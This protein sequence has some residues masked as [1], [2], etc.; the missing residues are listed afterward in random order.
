MSLISVNTN[1]AGL[2]L[3]K[4]VSFTLTET[5]FPVKPH[6]KDSFCKTMAATDGTNTKNRSGSSLTLPINEDVLS[7]VDWLA[8][9]LYKLG[10]PDRSLEQW[11]ERLKC[12]LEQA[13][14]EVIIV[15]NV[16]QSFTTQE[17]IKAFFNTLKFRLDYSIGGGE[18]SFIVLWSASGLTEEQK[19]NLYY[20]EL[21]FLDDLE[22]KMWKRTFQ[23][24]E[25]KGI[26]VGIFH[27]EPHQNLRDYLKSVYQ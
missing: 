4:S 8:R 6:A 16:S 1:T 10:R 23:M 5:G 2:P 24:L 22:L 27:F 14:K 21:V 25:E 3:P 20:Q 26:K 7:S 17:I 18:G 9:T 19:N 13:L 11:N 15:G 12:I